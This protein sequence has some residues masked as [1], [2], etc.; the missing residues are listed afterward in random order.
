LAIDH[1][2]FARVLRPLGPIPGIT[3]VEMVDGAALV[4]GAQRRVAMTDGSVVL[5]EILDH[6]PPRRHR[7]CWLKP[8][9]PPFSWLV[10]T[11]EG[12]WVFSPAGE[13]TDLEWT[14]SFELPSPLAAPLAA[15]V[16]LL[17]RRWMA[18][19]LERIRAEAAAGKS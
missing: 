6:A 18:N 5:E 4:P 17:F 7:Y 12:D 19:G 14:Y 8:P 13:G 10:R 2:T 15:P 3:G 1:A 11:G 16:L 9:A